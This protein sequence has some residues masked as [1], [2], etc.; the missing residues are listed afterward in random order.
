VAGLVGTEGAELMKFSPINLGEL[1]GLSGSID[2]PISESSR[3]RANVYVFIDGDKLLWLAFGSSTP[4][5]GFVTDKTLY[6]QILG[7]LQ[8]RN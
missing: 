1:S 6:E 5:E 3:I 2:Q 8:V 4:T 7:T